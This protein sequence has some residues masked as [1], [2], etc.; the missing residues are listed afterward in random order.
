MPGNRRFFAKLRHWVYRIILVLTPID[1]VRYREFEFVCNAVQQ[2]QHNPRRILDIS[3]PKLIPVTMAHQAP[4]APVHAVDIV[5]A[6]V[7]FLAWAQSELPLPN[8][9]VGQ[10][11]S[12]CL[13][14]Q[15]QTF[16]LITSISVFEHIAPADG[17]EIPASQELARVLKPGG[18]AILTVP[19]ARQRFAE[20]RTGGVYERAAAQNEQNF[21][22]RFY[23]YDLL[24]QNIVN[25]SGLELL[26]LGF[27][28]ERFFFQNPRIRLAHYIGGTRWRNLLFGL[29]YPLLAR[30]FLTQPKPLEATQ[31]PY[32]ACIVL[33]KPQ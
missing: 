23:D 22:Q 27:I 8:L 20:Y 6:E 16:D 9:H 10:Q 13:G 31:K 2:H 1:F 26:Q 21:F 24:M 30:I 17:G 33:R 28:E 5:S 11:D 15:Q 3:S 14:Y 12:R 19:F 4:S 25:A 29:W 32:I 7:E 18:I